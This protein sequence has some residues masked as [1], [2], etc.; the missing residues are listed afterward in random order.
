MTSNSKGDWLRWLIS[1]LL[2]VIGTLVLA[3]GAVCWRKLDGLD[4]QTTAIQHVVLL[5]ACRIGVVE[6]KVDI[7]DG[8]LN[9]L[10]GA[11]I[12]EN[13]VKTAAQWVEAAAGAG[14]RAEALADNTSANR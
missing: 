7:L 14:L 11:G 12:R 9:R 4:Q 6:A 5:Q 13:D 2:V 8:K 1:G 3:I 10:L